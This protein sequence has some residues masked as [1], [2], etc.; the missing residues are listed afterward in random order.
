MFAILVVR[1]LGNFAHEMIA[2]EEH[3]AT[4]EDIYA[5]IRVK[6]GDRQL[7]AGKFVQEALDQY[8]F[9]RWRNVVVTTALL[10]PFLSPPPTL[11]IIA[12]YYR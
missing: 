7:P 10:A 6:I 12:Q 8:M 9:Q 5:A 11:A 3:A 1:I 2:P 4:R